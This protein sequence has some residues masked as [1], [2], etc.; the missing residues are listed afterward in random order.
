MTIVRAVLSTTIAVTLMAAVPAAQTPASIDVYR[1]TV[2]AYVSGRDINRAVAAIQS[3]SKK[4]FESI[5]DQLAIVANDQELRAAAVLH[6][7]FG[8]ASVERFPEV[9]E[10][11]LAIGARLMEASTRWLLRQ[12]LATDEQ[13]AMQSTWLGVAASLLLSINDSKRARPFVMDGLDIAPKSASMWTQF[14][15]LNELEAAVPVVDLW[16]VNIL[17]PRFSA[18]Q[19]LAFIAVDAYRKAIEYDPQHAVAHLRLGRVLYILDHLDDARAAI[20][21]AQVL[22]TTPREKYLSALTMGAILER[23]KDLKGARASYERALA[24]SPKGQAAAVALGHLDVIE[25]R[26]DRAQATA[27]AFFT[28]PIDDIDWSEFK[29]GGIDRDRFAWLRKQVRR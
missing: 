19:R 15:A 10:W 12:R 26:P 17:E 29:N 23:R 25:G 27:E 20:E 5:R 9:A 4:D 11:H 16:T 2:A 7:E 24:V 6:L 3:W 1:S 22:A 18:R 8:A 13:V 14:G 21:R 28:D